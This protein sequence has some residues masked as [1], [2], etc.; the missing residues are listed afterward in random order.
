MNLLVPSEVLIVILIDVF[1]DF[2][3]GGFLWFRPVCHCQVES[4]LHS[5]GVTVN[6]EAAVGCRD[7]VVPHVFFTD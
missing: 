4:V 3:D 1:E 2:L 6:Y 5:L 7:E